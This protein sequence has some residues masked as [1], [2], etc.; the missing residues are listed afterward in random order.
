MKILKGSR[1]FFLLFTMIFFFPIVTFATVDKIDNTD[2][3]TEA[4][5]IIEKKENEKEVE[6]DKET[7]Y[8]PKKAVPLR[9]LPNTGEVLMSFIYI[10]V[11]LSVLIFIFG[12]IVSKTI[13]DEIRWEY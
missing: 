10:I 13:H 4:D 5:V 6:Q 12:V 9:V 7:I 1:W 2:R 3:V 8:T 11:G